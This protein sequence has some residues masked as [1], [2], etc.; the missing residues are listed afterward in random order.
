MFNIPRI[1]IN[2]IREQHRL[3]DNEIGEKLVSNKPR[4]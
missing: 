3:K 2:S 4:V 1:A